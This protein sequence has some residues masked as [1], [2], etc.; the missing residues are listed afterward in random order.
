MKRI[1]ALMLIAA[2]L[3]LLFGCS[4]ANGPVRSSSGDAEPSAPLSSSESPSGEPQ[5]PEDFLREALA[6]YG[7]FEMSIL[8]SYID[9]PAPNG[10]KAYLAEDE[11]FRRYNDFYG[12]VRGM[13]SQQIT[14]ELFARGIYIN[15]DGNNY[16]REMP[17]SYGNIV[18]DV[19]MDDVGELTPDGKLVYTVTVTFGKP[20]TLEPDRTET[21]EFIAEPEGGRYV[22]TQ[23]PY[24]Y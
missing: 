18:L 20:V 11:K 7:F 8:E 16:V 23:F 17:R 1:T 21:L 2:A 24:F 10:E 15:V 3:L 19:E 13:F 6:A 12:Y 22:F 9:F 4:G 5:I 14:D